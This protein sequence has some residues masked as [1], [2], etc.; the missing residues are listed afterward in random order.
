MI[1]CVHTIKMKLKGKVN[2]LNPTQLEKSMKNIQ[3]DMSCKS[4]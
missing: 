4:K 3:E 2:I 1:R